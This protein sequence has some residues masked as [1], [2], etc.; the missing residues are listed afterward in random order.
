MA[1]EQW[2]EDYPS[3]R[4]RA[5]VRGV[6]AVPERGQIGMQVAAL[7]LISEDHRFGRS[8]SSHRGITPPLVQVALLPRLSLSIVWRQAIRLASFA[9]SRLCTHSH[10]QAD[11]TPTWLGVARH[12]DGSRTGGYLYRPGPLESPIMVSIEAI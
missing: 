6:A 11:S 7:D 12:C 9:P 2:F 1:D 3:R 5:E 4:P 10:G 8:H